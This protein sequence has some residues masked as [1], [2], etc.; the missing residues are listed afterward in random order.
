MSEINNWPEEIR[1]A[2]KEE[3][4]KTG[5]LGC[6]S[7]KN[8]EWAVASVRKEQDKDFFTG[9]KIEKT[10]IKVD[11][12]LCRAGVNLLNV[13]KLSPVKYCTAHNVDVEYKKAE[14]VDES[15]GSLFGG[16]ASPR[17][18]GLAPGVFGLGSD[19]LNK[20]RR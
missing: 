15:T 20:L 5:L 1:S 14:S 8:S 4:A 13:N 12:V 2:V 6:G 9:R 11:L 16:K 3:K 18:G 7:C 10:V 17:A 19:L